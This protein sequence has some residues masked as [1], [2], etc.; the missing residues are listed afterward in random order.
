MIVN[1]ENM[2]NACKIG[3]LTATDLADYLVQKQNMPFR[4]AYYLTKEVVEKANSL[5]KDISE[6]N[7]NEI[8]TSSNELANI[9]EEIVS[10]LSLKNSMNSRNSFGGTSTLETEKQVEGF[11]NW[12]KSEK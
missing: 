7:I 5:N 8:R 9:D 4:E 11:K 3:H 12:L 6:L 1:V 10:Y 2:A